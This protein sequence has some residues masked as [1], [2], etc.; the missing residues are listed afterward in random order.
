MTL[1]LMTFVLLSNVALYSN[2]TLISVDGLARGTAN[3]WSAAYDLDSQAFSYSGNIGGDA[4][5]I[6]LGATH[7]YLF[8]DRV[9][10]TISV[11][12]AQDGGVVVGDGVTLASFTMRAD[13]HIATFHDA[14]DANGAFTI[15][16]SL[17][18]Q[19]PDWYNPSSALPWYATKVSEWDGLGLRDRSTTGVWVFDTTNSN[20]VYDSNG[21]LSSYKGSSYIIGEDHTSWNVKVT[22]GSIVNPVPVPEPRTLMLMIL[23]L[24]GIAY[25]RVRR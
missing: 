2:A 4:T 23:S 13:R 25:T 14:I 10:N 18:E 16:A 21:I 9:N 11:F 8:A 12:G 15:D 20:F 6:S 1:K 19:T 24:I 3:Y 22:D 17:I 5:W 7:S